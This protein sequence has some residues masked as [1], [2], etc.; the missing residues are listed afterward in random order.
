MT[1]DMKIFHRVIIRK[2]IPA[3]K[4]MPH[5]I[6]TMESGKGFSAATT[7]YRAAGTL[8]QPLHMAESL[9]TR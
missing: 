2:V 3:D 6:Y 4:F 8:V 5:L 9:I 7:Y 1:D